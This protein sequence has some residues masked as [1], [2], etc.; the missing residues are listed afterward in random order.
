MNGSSKRNAEAERNWWVA[1]R[2]YTPADTE[3]AGLL[4][5]DPQQ[6]P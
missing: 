1:E 5:S 3:S 6:S 4:E 2:D